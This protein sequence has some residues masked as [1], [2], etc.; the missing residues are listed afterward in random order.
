MK[1][2]RNENG[3]RGRAAAEPQVRAERGSGNV[4]AD[5]GL[6]N[7]ELALAKAKLVQRIEDVV[8][9]RGLTD[10]AAADLLGLAPAKFVALARGKTG[11]YSLDRL[12][13][14]LTVLGQRVEITVRP[15]AGGP[16]SED[17]HALL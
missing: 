13:R 6:P 3:K 12:F 17:I 7:P 9:E 11:G 16:G 10:A 8:H 1:T 4:F 2:A 5:L 15:A 14:F